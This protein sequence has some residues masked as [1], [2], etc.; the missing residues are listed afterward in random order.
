MPAPPARSAKSGSR[1]TRS[2]G[3]TAPGKAA[4]P[5]PADAA[6]DRITTVTDTL[7]R[8]AERG[9]FRGFD[10][11]PVRRGVATYRFHWLGERRLTLAFDPEAG[12]Y[13][14]P[15]LLPGIAR[16]SPLAADLE[17]FLDERRGTTLPAHRR[18][19]PGQA[20]VAWSPARGSLS[21][22][23]TLVRADAAW[24][25]TRVVNLVHEVFVHLQSTWPDYVWEHLGGSTE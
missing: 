17:T 23:L 5:K 2:R 8:Y 24:G 10:A 9:V 16:R 12:R 6:V 14:F 25:S 18:V 7:R 20:V 21:L 11:L 3:R 15:A 22:E 19:A 4:R 13:T 1:A